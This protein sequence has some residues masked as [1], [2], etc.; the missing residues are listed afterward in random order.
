MIDSDESDAGDEQLAKTQM[1]SS[2]ERWWAEVDVAIETDGVACG[3]FAPGPTVTSLDLPTHPGACPCG[4]LPHL[5]T[6][7]YHRLRRL[8]EQQLQRQS[9]HQHAE[10]VQPDV[11]QLEAEEVA[12]FVELQQPVKRRRITGKQA[13]QSS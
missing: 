1:M 2:D 4:R 3:Y 13:M 12:S 9:E 8:R 10:A 6:C 5:C 7:E 11:M